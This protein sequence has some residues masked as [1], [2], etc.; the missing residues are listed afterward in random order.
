MKKNVKRLIGLILV[1]A[2]SMSLGC[3][4]LAATPETVGQYK[5]YVAL[6]DSV[7]SGFG[8]PD[9]NKY[10]KL[11]VIGERIEGSYPDLV[12]DYVQAHS[13]APWCVPGFGSGELRYLVDN[14]FEGTHL[15]DTELE[16]LSFGT[17]SR[18]TMDTWRPIVQQQIR[19]ADLITLDI[20]LNDIWMGP[21]GLVYEIAEYGTITGDVRGTLQEELAKYGTW[22][23]V[24]RNTQYMLTG[25]MQNPDKW[26]YFSGT[27][28]QVLYDYFTAF[29][30]NFTAIVECIYEMNPDVT[31]VV[32]SSFNSFKSFQLISHGTNAYAFTVQTPTGE[33]LTFD[34]P[35]LG[36]VTIPK[37]IHVSNTLIGNVAQPMYDFEYDAVRQSFVSKYPGQ[38]F[39]ADIGEVELIGDH[40]TVP[41]Y[42]NTSMDDSG[43]NPH[44][45]TAGHKY[46]ADQII[47]VLPDKNG[48][49]IDPVPDTPSIP[50]QHANCPSVKYTDLDTSMWYHEPVDYVLNKGIMTG[51]TATTFE[52]ETDLTRAQVAT[53][54]YAMEGKPA[55]SSSAGFYDVPA[56]E[57]FADPVNWCAGTGIVAGM[58]DGGFAPNDNVT[59]EQLVT[60]LR[61]YA[62]YK[63]KNVEP[64]GDASGFAD[65]QYISYWAADSVS[66]AIGNG[67]ISGREGNL[68][69]PQGTASRA[70]AATMFWRFCTKVLD[71]N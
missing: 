24:I 28:I 17:Y 45:T 68:L 13:M 46:I 56:D 62:E 70:E 52:P 66:W 43:Y 32:P 29:K 67:L 55:V 54:L 57:W 1:L 40:L 25:I 71:M 19:E 21:I 64:N 12:A 59:R 30:E 53:I 23:T 60:M 65:S 2:L 35:F 9:Y 4:A 31:V 15:M 20:G 7:G 63:G 37:E 33:P 10:G 36:T 47:S 44:P 34:L 38:Y 8:Q 49:T 50:S 48:E 41:L 11:V 27:L 61:S 22:E 3:S 18:E 26:A 16:N 42:E 51:T 58:G 6:G 39:Y 14:S 69:A 5:N